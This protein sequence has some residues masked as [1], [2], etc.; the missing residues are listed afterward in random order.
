MT[1]IHRADV[2]APS[3]TVAPA[4]TRRRSGVSLV[5][6]LVAVSLLSLSLLALARISPLMN[7]YGRKNDMQLNR[8][9]VLQQQADRIMAMPDSLISNTGLTGSLVTGTK[10]LTIQG[11]KW[12]RTVSMTNS[13]GM[14]KIMLI[15]KPLSV[16]TSLQKPDTLILWRAPTSTC[17][18]NT[19]GTC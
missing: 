5:E 14:Q 8:A 11:Y 6:V 18:L 16:S 17:L 7:T 4:T 1:H 13:S 3:P 12:Q 2:N 19:T 10:T 15:M 9:Y